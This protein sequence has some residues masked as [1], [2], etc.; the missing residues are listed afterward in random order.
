[1][2]SCRTRRVYYTTS[3]EHETE[4]E[5][6]GCAQVFVARESG[7]LIQGTVCVFAVSVSVVVFVAVCVCA[8]SVVLNTSPHSHEHGNDSIVYRAVER[9]S[10]IA[11][12]RH[13]FRLANRFLLE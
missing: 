7:V 5:S 3:S 4:I 1:V 6:G 10:L 12:F 9:D 2:R 13:F 8:T 11:V